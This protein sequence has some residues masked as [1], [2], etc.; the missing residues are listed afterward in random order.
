MTR[1]QFSSLAEPLANMFT[2]QQQESLNYLTTNGLPLKGAL[3][4][5]DKGSPNGYFGLI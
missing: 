5:V 4:G 1:G 3:G 2:R